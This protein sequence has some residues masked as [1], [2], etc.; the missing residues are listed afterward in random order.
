MNNINTKDIES[1][2]QDTLVALEDAIEE[3]S[4]NGRL[5]IGFAFNVKELDKLEELLSTDDFYDQEY[6]FDYIDTVREI[7]ALKQKL[8]NYGLHDRDW[9]SGVT[10]ISNSNIQR[11]V[12]DECD[13]YLL[14][15]I[16]EHISEYVTFNVDKLIHERLQ[17][18]IE[19]SFRNWY[20][21]IDTLNMQSYLPKPT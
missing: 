1:E 5:P 15:H 3:L 6:L 2:Y 13:E 14:R 4:T 12:R 18:Y 9:E 21:W 8:I 19:F 11:I 20:Y 10:L 16:P 7:D 17:E